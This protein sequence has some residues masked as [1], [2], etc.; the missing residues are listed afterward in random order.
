MNV[1]IKIFGFVPS[2]FLPFDQTG[3]TFH[4]KSASITHRLES[5]SVGGL[6][7]GSTYL[8]LATTLNFILAFI[9][10]EMRLV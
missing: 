4:A 1:K 9:I 5:R 10:L 2:S 6:W 3:S 7:L 8:A